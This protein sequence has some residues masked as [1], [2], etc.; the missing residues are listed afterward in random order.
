MELVIGGAYQGKL[1]YAKKTYGL[2]EGDIFCC[3][4][5]STSVDRS[6]KCVCHL[7]FYVLS[8]IYAGIRPDLEFRKD[9]VLICDDISCGVV[10]TD[11]TLRAWREE[12]GRTLGALARQAEHVTRIFC[13]LP[14]KLK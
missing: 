3:G 7:E 4:E 9:A 13:G 2:A 5:G 11:T 1:D 14:Q 12:T 8:C 6:R 10:P